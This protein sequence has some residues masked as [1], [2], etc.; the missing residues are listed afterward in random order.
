MRQ[1]R[2]LRE[3]TTL[4]TVLVAGV[5][6]LIGVGFGPSAKQALT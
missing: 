2:Y 4:R 3:R 1:P 6:A 5:A